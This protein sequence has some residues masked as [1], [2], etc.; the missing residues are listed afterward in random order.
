[1]ASNAILIPTSGSVKKHPEKLL[2]TPSEIRELNQ[3]ARHY[4]ALDHYS[5]TPVRIPSLGLLVKYGAGVLYSEYE[6]QL[7][8]YQQL[9]G[10]V[11]VP[12]LYGWTQDA[13]Q[14]FIYMALIEGETLE[15]RWKGMTGEEKRNLALE[16]RE[17]VD[18]WRSLTQPGYVS[19]IGV[20][21][22][23]A[24]ND[25]TLSKFKGGPFMGENAIADFHTA[26]NIS[27]IEGD[28]PIKFTHADLVACNIL[29]T[30]GPNPKVAAVID[31]E[32]AGWYPSYWE[33]CKAQTVGLP[34]DAHMDKN[35]EREWREEYL[36]LILDPVDDETCFGPWEMWLY[37]WG[38]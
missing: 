31:W 5:P 35:D 25:R 12:E 18:T 7:F 24:L 34:T 1:M 10:R 17:M 4:K 21:G 36:P 28:F 13:G 23:Q 20:V 27:G 29:V 15:R 16:L 26:C 3:K 38:L 22:M 2:P 11:L 19:Y 32:Q 30:S 33:Y 14:G 6:A 9:Q 8:V 37:S